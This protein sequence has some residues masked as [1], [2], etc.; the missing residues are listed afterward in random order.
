MVFFKSALIASGIKEELEGKVQRA[1]AR[2]G[3]ARGASTGPTT[4]DHQLVTR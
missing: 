3:K 4:Q 1:V 2:D